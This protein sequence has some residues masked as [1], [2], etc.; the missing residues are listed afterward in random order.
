[1]PKAL[2]SRRVESSAMS[3]LR[4]LG[5]GLPVRRTFGLEVLRVHEVHAVVNV[6]LELPAPEPLP[7]E[8]LRS[9]EERPH[10]VAAEPEKP[11]EADGPLPGLL[12]ENR[13]RQIR[14]QTSHLV[15]RLPGRG[16]RRAAALEGPVDVILDQDPRPGRNR[17]AHSRHYRPPF[18][19]GERTPPGGA[20]LDASDYLASDRGR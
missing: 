11:L 5:N 4:E 17:V 19:P 7:D 12:D 14:P 16:I 8:C 13:A 20:N 10:L 2:R 18:P 9:L 15:Q 1:M 6:Q 3:I